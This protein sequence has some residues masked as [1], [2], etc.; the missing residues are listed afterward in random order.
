M[1]ILVLAAVVTPSPDFITQGMLAV[2]MLLLY[3]LSI[4]VSRIT[5]RRKEAAHSA[6]LQEDSRS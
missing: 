1:V 2:P 3:E 5:L 6:A 4:H